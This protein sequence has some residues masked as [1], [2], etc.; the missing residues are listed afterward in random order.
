MH[1]HDR[2]EPNVIRPTILASMATLCCVINS[3][4]NAT[5][6]VFF[7]SSQLA[8]QVASGVT[9]DTINSMGY[10]FTYTRDKLFT[11]GGSEPIGRMVRIPWPEGVEAQAVT[12]GPN[13]GKAK[14]TV[15]RVDG[16]VFD[17]AA[18][19]AK[20][21]ANTAG[22]GGSFEVVPFLN[23]EEIL[24]D[25][26]V[27][28]ATG[29]AGS[30]FSYDTSPNPLGTTALLTGFDKYT[31]DL[32][33]DFAWTALTL[34]GAP[35]PPGDVNFDG[36]VNIFDVNLVSAHWGEAGPAGDANEDGVVD[37][38]DVNLISA[39]WT[40]IGVTAVPEPSTLVL[41]ALALG[42]LVGCGGRRRMH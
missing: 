18:F 31:I 12:A 10:L 7:D 14:I 33:V 22:A 32:Y 39:N 34:E 15:E 40:A 38:F 9:S 23:G 25:P 2:Q 26:V 30:T 27:F 16:D 8:T 24:P 36:V 3:T 37:I 5:T 28:D 20:L 29:F 35:L 21:L 17:L 11:G 13:P 42:G 1:I 19:T 4:A 41:A 6:V